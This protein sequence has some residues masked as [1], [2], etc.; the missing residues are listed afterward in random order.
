LESKFLVLH[1]GSNLDHRKGFLD[2]ALEE[3]NS[4]FGELI[5]ISSI[6]ETQAWG[7]GDQPD[8]LNMAVIY[9]C[10]D[11]LEEILRIIKGIELSVG[12]QPRKR[13]FEREIDIDIIFYGETSINIPHL[14]IPHPQ[15]HE[16]RFV[17]V[18]LHEICPEC[19]HPVFD[20]NVSQ[21]LLECTDT[22][23]VDF[24]KEN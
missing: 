13:W 22:L 9:K 16:R 12:R 19:I 15:M 20:K 4:F 10:A 3:L 11:S 17:L 7:K 21:L 6:Y 18:P 14:Q 5:A 2:K 8:F 23:H 24:W 1:L